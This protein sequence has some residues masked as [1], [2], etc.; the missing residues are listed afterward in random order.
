MRRL[1]TTSFVLIIACAA[2]GQTPGE[3]TITNSLGMKL[4]RIEAGTFVMGSSAEPPKSRAEW[5]QRDADEAPAHKVTISRPFYMGVHEVTNA[6]YE[7]FDPDHKKLRGGQWNVSKEDNEPVTYVTWQQA[8]AFCEWLTKKENRVYRLPTE[9]EWE[10]ACR[11]GTTGAY[12]TGDIITAEQAN[13]GLTVD[14]KKITTTPVGAYPANPWGLFDMHGNVQEWCL[15]WYGPY[16]ASA[17]TDPVGRAEGYAR[18]TRGWS[19]LPANRPG[20]RYTR[21]ANRS[22]LLPEDANRATGFRVVLGESPK[23]QPLPVVAEAYQKDVA[24]K[25]KAPAVD[26]TTPYFV[27]YTAAGKNPSIPKESWGPLFSAHNHFAAVTACPNGDVLCAWYTTV[28]ESGREMTQGCSRLRAGSDR[29]EPASPFFDVPDVNDH[30]PVLF[31][32]GKRLYHFGTQS[33]VGWDN[34]SN[35]LRTSDDN[36]ATWSAPRIILSR[37]DPKALSQPC[38]CVLTRDGTLLLACDGDAH[39]DERLMASSDRGETWKVAAGDFRKT[40]GRYVIHPTFIERGDGSLLAWLRGPHPMPAFEST[41]RGESWTEITTRFPGI[42][43]GQ[44]TAALKLRSGAVVLVS[45]DT[46]KAL[47]GGGTFAAMSL[48]DGKT[49]PHVRKLDGVSGYMAITQATNDVIH[50]VGTRMQ[51]VAFNEAWLRAGTPLP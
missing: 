24:Q 50:V 11:A 1:L 37:D 47:T 27:N 30:A 43:V 36:G 13:L 15:D 21:S 14:G 18:V 35:F 17:Q 23:S 19:F 45:P 40:A 51:A 26:A 48:D 33:L 16:D 29:W 49:W 22:G 5:E 38:T 7:A 44:R 12:S 32:D 4:V 6:Q 41:D 42:S 25:R 39:R 20:T 3:K 8:A 2:R 46:K 10:Y 34:A 9:A 28:S 31:S